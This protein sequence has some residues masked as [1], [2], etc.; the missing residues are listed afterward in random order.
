[1]DIKTSPAVNYDDTAVR[2][3]IWLPS[4]DPSEPVAGMTSFHALAATAETTS[5]MA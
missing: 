1:M 2:Q 3:F 4:E 5:L